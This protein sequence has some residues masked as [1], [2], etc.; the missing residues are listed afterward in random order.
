MF[1]SKIKQQKQTNE[2]NTY[3][4]ALQKAKLLDINERTLMLFKGTRSWNYIY[5]KLYTFA[6]ISEIRTI[7]KENRPILYTS[8]NGEIIANSKLRIISKE[9][10]AGQTYGVLVSKGENIIYWATREIPVDIEEN[11][12]R[13]HYF[14]I[15]EKYRQK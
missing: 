1:I 4:K 7:G 5:Q 2:I 8:Y 14:N 6:P 15:I 13:L 11:R 12:E 10:K 9:I 3:K